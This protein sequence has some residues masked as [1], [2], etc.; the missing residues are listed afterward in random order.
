[1]ANKLEKR[2]AAAEEE[3]SAK[4]A[5][6]AE[7]TDA[8]ENAAGAEDAAGE[9]QREICAQE[10][11]TKEPKPKMPRFMKFLM[12]LFVLNFI[13][14]AVALVLTS[15]NDVTYTPVRLLD[16]FNVVLEV[17]IF[18][19]V[20]CRFKVARVCTM[21][22]AVFNMVVMWSVHFAL[23]PN[24]SIDNV[25]T[26]CIP[27][28]ILL[29]YFGLSKKARAYL[30]Q[31]FTLQNNEVA[32]AT[33]ETVID[34]RKWPFYR[35]LIIYFCVFSLLG[36]WFEAGCSKLME[37]GVIKGEVDYSNTMMWRDWFYPY[38]MHGFAVVLIALL[39]YPF[40]RWLLKKC[41][42]RAFAYGISFMANMLVCVCIEFFMGLAV[43]S[44]LQ[45]WNYTNMPFNIMGQVCLQNALGFGV[46]ASLIAWWVYPALERLCARVPKNAMNVIFVFTVAAYMIPQTLYLIDPPDIPDQEFHFEINIGGEDGDGGGGE[47]SGNTNI[48]TNGGANGTN[49]NSAANGDSDTYTFNGTID[50]A[51]DSG[52][53]YKW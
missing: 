6:A 17:V 30:T 1:M 38:P 34:R 39:L 42:R 31:P 45:L 52:Y 19:L 13:L 12:V 47:G 3:A 33:R 5:A 21:A 7:Q 11:A 48:N 14:T 35:N 4:E 32:K 28:I 20:C 18:W 41:P 27:N 43:N 51:L 46:A 15:R 10:T 24:A 26:E 37:L 36:H 29:L 40:W 44:N 9:K 22:L 25:T 2:R 8:E 50:D 23:N 49:T 16:F 53:E